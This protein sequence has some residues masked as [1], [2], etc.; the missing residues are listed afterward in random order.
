MTMTLTFVIPILII[1]VIAGFTAKSMKKSVNH[2]GKSMSSQWVRRI[3]GA[4]ISL[5]LI[6]ALV[7]TFINGKD[8]NDLKKA[9]VD[10]LEK[11]GIALVDAAAAGKLDT[12]DSSFIE[13]KWDLDYRDQKLN[14][15]TETAEFFGTQIFVERKNTND[16]KIDAIAYRTR[17]SV[18]DMDISKLINPI[19][20]K[21]AGNILI[22]QNPKKAKLEFSMFNNVFSVNQFTGEPSLFEH[23][24]SF[25]DGQSILYMRIPKDLE[26]IYKSDL[27]IQ[28]VE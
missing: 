2:K 3:F 11:E 13:K 28:Y 23:Q 25:Y 7:A 21:L 24:S 20:L 9:E 16:H 14:V 6:C 17:S 1:L 5:L 4:Y 22:L 15:T 8:N 18:N 27:N 12:I 26:L 10:S 19:R